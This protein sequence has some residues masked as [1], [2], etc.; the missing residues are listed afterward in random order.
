MAISAT[1]ET[2]TSL[3]KETLYQKLESGKVTLPFLVQ[4][5][6]IAGKYKYYLVHSES[7]Y[8][9]N[10]LSGYGY[11]SLEIKNGAL[12]NACIEITNTHDW[13]LSDRVFTLENF[14]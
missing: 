8:V 11:L 12:K 1:V 7:L 4:R 3:D 14:L 10:S 5:K 6:D 13:E 9:D 2:E